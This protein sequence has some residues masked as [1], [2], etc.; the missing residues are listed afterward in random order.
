MA[1]GVGAV[2]TGLVVVLTI[3][4]LSRPILPTLAPSQGPTSSA[5]SPPTSNPN[6][7]PL[8]QATARP[9][10][11]GERL[12]SVGTIFVDAASGQSLRERIAQTQAA[13][14]VFAAD[15]LLG[16]GPGRLYA[17]TNSSGVRVEGYVLDT[18]L[19]IA[20][21]FGL[22]GTVVLLALVGV[23]VWFIRLT[24]RTMGRGPEH[25]SVVGL[26]TTF[27]LTSLLGP[28]MDDKGAAYALAL[29]LTIALSVAAGTSAD[30][31]RPTDVD[32]AASG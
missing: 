21:E 30:I 11:I 18:P 24:R 19:M 15:P 1:I 16:S 20:A 2:T 22:L 8:A 25:L 4:A 26:A 5:A 7:S 12:G 32:E 17:W 27:G 14:L 23:F 13:F 6:V 28:P 3:A 9:G 31:G 10:L 29:V